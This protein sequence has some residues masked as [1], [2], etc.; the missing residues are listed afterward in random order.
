MQCQ[1]TLPWRPANKRTS[2]VAPLRASETPHGA[3]VVSAWARTCSSFALR[4]LCTTV[5]VAVL[6]HKQAWRR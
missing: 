1:T 2:R 6:R 3:S 5:A 4:W